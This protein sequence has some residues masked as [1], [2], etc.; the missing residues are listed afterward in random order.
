MERWTAAMIRGVVIVN[1]LSSKGLLALVHPTRTWAY[2]PPDRAADQPERWSV[3]DF[4]APDERG[5]EIAQLLGDSLLPGWYC[6]FHSDDTVWV[7][8]SGRCF[9]YARG[10]TRGRE[11]RQSATVGKRGSLWPSWTGAKTTDDDRPAMVAVQQ[12]DG[13]DWFSERRNASRSGAGPARTSVPSRKFVAY[14]GEQSASLARR[15]DDGIS[16][17]FRGGATPPGA[18][19]AGEIGD[20]LPTRD[21]RVPVCASPSAAASG[22]RPAGRD[23]A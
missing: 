22:R 19:R 16:G 3:V 20:E 13:A 8:F 11:L 6:D 12:G 10:D 17:I 18:P 7:A 21:T 4:E 1:S 2:E 5:D 15:A 23:E 9:K 14:F